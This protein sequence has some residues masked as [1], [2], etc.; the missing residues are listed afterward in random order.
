MS[1]TRGVAVLVGAGDAIGA[2]VARRFAKGG[3][4]VCICR[5]DGAKSQTLVDE[6]K[7]AGHNVHAFSVDA[8]QA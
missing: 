5:R 3:Y 4:T 7:V 2:A 8:R 6:L 1:E